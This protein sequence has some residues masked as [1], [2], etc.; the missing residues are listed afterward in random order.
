[1]QKLRYV[2]R[3]SKPESDPV[4]RLSSFSALGDVETE[5]AACNVMTGGWDTNMPVTLGALGEDFAGLL[6]TFARA[7]AERGATVYYRLCPINEAALTEDSD[8]DSW[9][10]TVSAQ[11]E[12]PI[13][14]DPA[15]SILASG[16]FFDTNFHLNRSGRTV[17]T[18]R[19]IRALKA[20][21]RDSSPTRAALPVMPEA[22]PETAP[23]VESDLFTVEDGLLTGVTEKGK[24]QEALTIPEGV[25]RIADGAFAGCTPLREIHLPWTDPTRCSPGQDLLR[26]TDA[27]LVVPAGCGDRYKLN[28]SWSVYADRIREE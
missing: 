25:T 5:L 24:T 14:G 19:L 27:V 20:E 12:F 28:Y 21:L 22:S 9:W 11:L 18:Y 7:A 23:E 1:M 13:L 3:G 26:G 17:N 16:W 15:E 2:L 10:E 4:Y 8:P 6:N